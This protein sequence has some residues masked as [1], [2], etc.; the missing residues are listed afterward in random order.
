MLNPTLLNSIPAYPYL[1]NDFMIFKDYYFVLAGNSPGALIKVY[2]L[3]D[4]RSATP[5][6]PVSVIMFGT[7][8]I[9][10]EC[11]IFNSEKT[12]IG[13]ADYSRFFFIVAS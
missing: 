7:E 1:R 8:N 10:G 11:I 5:L 9:S 3:S 12:L 2:S 4:V 6:I 13:Y